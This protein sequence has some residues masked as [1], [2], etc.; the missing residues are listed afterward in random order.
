MV[1][2]LQLKSQVLYDPYYLKKKKYKGLTSMSRK[3]YEIWVNLTLKRTENYIFYLINHKD[4]I[5]TK[6][7][8]IFTDSI[9]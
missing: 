2:S 8:L 7:A 6:K 5:M 3:I 9:S 1:N 4:V